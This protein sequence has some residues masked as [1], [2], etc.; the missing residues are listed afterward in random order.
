MVELIRSQWSMPWLVIT[1]LLVFL[2]YW[3]SHTAPAQG[4]WGGEQPY[5][6][7]LATLKTEWIENSL[8]LSSVQSEK[9][10]QLNH[11]CASELEDALSRMDSGNWAEKRLVIQEHQTRQD[12]ALR[13]FLTS[14]Q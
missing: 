8:G 4:A 12:K 2:I 5:A 6:A 9:I 1:G 13:P 14:T 3:F 11:Q 7:S 10:R